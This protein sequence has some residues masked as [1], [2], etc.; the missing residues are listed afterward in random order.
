MTLGD[1]RDFLASLDGLPD[2]AAVKARTTMLRRRLRSLTV[3]EDD[4]GFHGYL[5]AVEGAQETGAPLT[6]PSAP[7]TSG[8]DVDPPDGRRR[9]RRNRS[10]V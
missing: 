1:L 5:Q 9:S 10:P 3:V 2:D 7:V 4:I 6:P 8:D